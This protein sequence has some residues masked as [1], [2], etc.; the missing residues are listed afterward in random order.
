MTCITLDGQVIPRQATPRRGGEAARQR[1]NEAA[2]RR[3]DEQ[4][5]AV[6]EPP[7]REEH[8]MT[9]NPAIHHRHSIRLPK[10]DY[11]QPGAYF[12]TLCTQDRECLL[13]KIIDGKMKLNDYGRIVAE[14]LEWLAKQYDY[15][16]LD[17]WVIMPDHLHVILIID[18]RCGGQNGSR[19]PIGRLVGAFKTVSTKNINILRQTPGAKLWQRDFWDHIGR[20]E[21][22]LNRIRRYIRNNPLRWES[23]R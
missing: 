19:K 13:G 20:D 8:T 15:V 23:G 16:I 7:Q 21:T 2:R 5:R 22:E 10:Y 14:S 9:Y 4:V 6:R 3:G 11:T 18:H 1:G 17:E 12:I